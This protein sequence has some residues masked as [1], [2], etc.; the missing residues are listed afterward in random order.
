MPAPFSEVS[1]PSLLP[2]GSLYGQNPQFVTEAGV[3][4]LYR[5]EGGAQVPK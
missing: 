2:V 1:R 3:N 5:Y 4:S